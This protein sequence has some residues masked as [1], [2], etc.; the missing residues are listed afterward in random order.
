MT[1]VGC[2]FALTGDLRHFYHLVFR[3]RI[4]MYQVDDSK[5]IIPEAM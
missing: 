3:T 2:L 5:F 1:E 4:T